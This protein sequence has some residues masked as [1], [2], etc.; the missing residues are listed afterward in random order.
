[1]R[2][3]AQHDSFTKIVA[4]QWLLLAKLRPLA[5]MADEESGGKVSGERESVGW[6]QGFGNQQHDN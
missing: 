5:G 2:G 1:M 4:Y 3:F 6:W